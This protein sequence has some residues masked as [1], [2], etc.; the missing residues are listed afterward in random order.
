ML[1]RVMFKVWA[2]EGEER[3]SVK[4]ETKLSATL[5]CSKATGYAR[6]R[7]PPLR[8]GVAAVMALDGLTIIIVV[9]SGSGYGSRRGEMEREG[10]GER[11][12]SSRIHR[13]HQKSSA[14]EEG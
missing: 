5:L 8:R 2:G 1:R 10:K 13:K 12:S 6:E 7:T 3:R 11:G 9:M 4:R 14:S